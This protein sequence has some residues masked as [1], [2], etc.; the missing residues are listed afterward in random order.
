MR[1]RSF[2]SFPSPRKVRGIV[3]LSISMPII[4]TMTIFFMYLLS[5]KVRDEGYQIRREIEV[6]RSSFLQ[7][8][9]SK[10]SEDTSEVHQETQKSI[11]DARTK[12]EEVEK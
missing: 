7:T 3:F 1:N 10:E 8:S 2:D 11:N 5:S 4:L 9:E 6:L 12:I